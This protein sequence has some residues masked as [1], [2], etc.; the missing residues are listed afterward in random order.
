MSFELAAGWSS[1]R[2]QSVSVV[3]I[4]QWRPHGMMKRTLVSVRSVIPVSA[5]ILLSP[6]AVHALADVHDTPNRPISPCAP[7]GLGVGWIVHAVVLGARPVM[8]WVNATLPVA[9]LTGPYTWV[10]TLEIRELE[11]RPPAR[12]RP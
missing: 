9:P 12:Q 6:K 8:C 2:F 1:P 3:P 10:L 11:H 7:V 4:S 5:L